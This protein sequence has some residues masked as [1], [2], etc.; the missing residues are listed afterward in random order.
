MT[1]GDIEAGEVD[2][3]RVSHLSSVCIQKLVSRG[4]HLHPGHH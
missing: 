1:E 2:R 3:A 4:Y